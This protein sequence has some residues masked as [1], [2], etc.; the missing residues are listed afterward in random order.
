MI[1]GDIAPLDELK[2]YTD[3]KAIKKVSELCYTVVWVI[4]SCGPSSLDL[5]GVIKKNM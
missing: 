5:K 3:E 1:K 2:N 4:N